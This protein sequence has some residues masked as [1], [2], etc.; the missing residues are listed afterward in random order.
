MVAA[1]AL[2]ISAAWVLVDHPFEGPVI[3]G[4]TTNHG[5][6]LTD[7]LAIVPLIWAWRTTLLRCLCRRGRRRRCA[8]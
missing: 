2:A 7:P 1:L 5:I 8:G 6:H 3:L 4:L